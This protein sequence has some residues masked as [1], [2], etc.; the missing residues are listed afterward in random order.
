MIEF[1]QTS[2]KADVEG[3]NKA[4]LEM[5][6]QHIDRL[7]SEY[8]ITEA[9]LLLRKIPVEEIPAKLRAE[10]AQLARRLG[11]HQRALKYLHGLIYDMTPEASMADKIEYASTIRRL[12]MINHSKAIL[13]GLDSVPEKWLY[14]SFCSIHLWNYSQASIE[15]SEY[16]KFDQLSTKQKTLAK[17]NLA[18]CLIQETDLDQAHHLLKSIEGSCQ[19]VGAYLYLNWLELMGQY[20]LKRG[21][22][23]DANHF[24]AQAKKS[25]GTENTN[26]T[27]WISKWTLL[28][29]ISEGSIRAHDES[30]IQF[31]KNLRKEGQWETLRDFDWQV[32]LITGS[33]D[34]AQS[35]FFGTP[36]ASFKT[37]VRSQLSPATLPLYV[38][39]RDLREKN[40]AQETINILGGKNLVLPFGKS[41]QRLA[42]MLLSDSYRPWSV[43]RIFDHLH[44]GELFSPTHST[45]KVY[46]VVERLK[47]Y[48]EELA[49]PLEMSSSRQGFRVRPLGLGLIPILETMCFD[50]NE[51]MKF[52]IVKFLTTVN[53]S[54]PASFTAHDVSQV[55]ELS[56]HQSYR[57]IKE[58]TDLGFLTPEQNGSKITYT[59]KKAA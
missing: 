55:L 42:L 6:A 37:K 32:S 11:L 20:S 4:E 8:K 28:V 24:L 17:I 14:N 26:A 1:Y 58:L 23:S 5:T 57:I 41:Q 2:K 31:K 18:A 49:I 13:D 29:K 35:V 46:Q 9:K 7:V 34:L 56:I 59:F 52:S 54:V 25:N 30:V 38:L 36:Y 47:A 12:G 51:E 10:F 22:L 33:K 21:A 43:Y 48:I 50:S 15:L 3:V 45:K 53:N 40:P 27:L 19:S 39:R 16:L 44:A